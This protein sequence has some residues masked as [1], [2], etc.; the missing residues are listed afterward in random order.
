MAKGEER[1]AVDSLHTDLQGPA[2]PLGPAGGTLRQLQ[3][4]GD[5]GNCAEET[6]PPGGANIQEVDGG[7]LYRKICAQ[8][9]PNCFDG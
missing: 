3:A 4:W 6:L 7:R 9:S 8:I 1:C 2:L 5:S